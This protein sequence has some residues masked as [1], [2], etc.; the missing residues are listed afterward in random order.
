[1]YPARLWV[2]DAPQIYIFN[3][4]EITVIGIIFKDITALNSLAMMWCN[5]PG[6]SILAFLGISSQ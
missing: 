3:K 6:A 1:M 4:Q 2:L 5:A